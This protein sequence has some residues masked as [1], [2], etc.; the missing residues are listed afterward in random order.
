MI[1]YKAKSRALVEP[2][3]SLL[4]AMLYLILIN[5]SMR[6]IAHYGGALAVILVTVLVVVA[7]QIDKTNRIILWPVINYVLFVLTSSSD[8][9]RRSCPTCGCHVARVGITP[10]MKAVG[11]K[12]ACGYQVKEAYPPADTIIVKRCPL[13]TPVEEDII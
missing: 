11:F 7:F 3:A 5:L 10:L 12:F 6:A 13:D 8:Y 2:V 9:M 1:W 4:M